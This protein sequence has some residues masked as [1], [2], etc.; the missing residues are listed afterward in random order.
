MVAVAAVISCFVRRSLLFIQQRRGERFNKLQ[1]QHASRP[2]ASI[3]LKDLGGT[4]VFNFLHDVTFEKREFL[5]IE[6]I[7]HSMT[8]RFV[9]ESA[10]VGYRQQRRC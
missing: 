10:G 1:R 7:D 4:K 2:L 6:Q 8:L 5:L 3:G 9:A